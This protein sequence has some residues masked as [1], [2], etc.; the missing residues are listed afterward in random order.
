V[1]VAGTVAEPLSG[2][3]EPAAQSIRVLAG[4][5]LHELTLVASWYGH[6]PQDA[7]MCLA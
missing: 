5:V 2:P 3:A 6:L 1:Y 4:G 7:G